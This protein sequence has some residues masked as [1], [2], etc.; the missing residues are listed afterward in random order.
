ML[1]LINFLRAI[2]LSTVE[3][4]EHAHILLGSNRT[5]ET[6]EGGDESARSFIVELL[7]MVGDT[8]NE[9]HSV[10]LTSTGR[11]APSHD[12]KH[13]ISVDIDLERPHITTKPATT[14][15]AILD[16]TNIGTKYEEAMHR[17]HMLSCSMR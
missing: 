1:G 10:S 6:V 16:L 15:T 4:L 13:N 8:E 17:Q 5:P 9:R 14:T 7:M 11:H 12:D 3:T 2:K